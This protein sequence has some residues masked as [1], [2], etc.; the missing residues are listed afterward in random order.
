MH[1]FSIKYQIFCSS[2]CIFNDV[3]HIKYIYLHSKMHLFL[4]SH[5]IFYCFVEASCQKLIKLL[6]F[7]PKTNYNIKNMILAKTL[8]FAITCQIRFWSPALPYLVCMY[9]RTVK[10]IFS[11]KS[12]NPVRLHVFPKPMLVA[13]FEAYRYSTLTIYN[14]IKYKLNIHLNFVF[15]DIRKRCDIRTFYDIRNLSQIRKLSNFWPNTV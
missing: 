9:I 10:I 15:V 5:S 11:D 13:K 8:G 12:A 14:K 1:T 4:K 3:I 7:M 2:K 6:S